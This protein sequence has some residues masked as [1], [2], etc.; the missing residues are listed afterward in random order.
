M[1]GGGMTALKP[2]PEDMGGACGEWIDV[3][4]GFER[5]M[6]TLKPRSLG[7]IAKD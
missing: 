1:K 3:G 5:G 6:T 2:C 7:N 4:E